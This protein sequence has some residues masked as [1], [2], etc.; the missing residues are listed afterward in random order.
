MTSSI[1]DKIALFERVLA[2]VPE[3]RYAGDPIL[4]TPAKSV[5]L[6]EGLL[7]GKR[8]EEVLLRFRAITGVGRGLAAPQIGEGASV[9]ITY[10][11]DTVETF[12][13]P[14]IVSTS[15]TNNMYKE[16]CMS[17]GIL[18]AEVERAE[19]IQMEWTDA[20]GNSRSGTFSGFLARLYQHE[21][22]H[23]QG[24]LNIDEATP[25]GIEFATFDPLQ[26]KLRPVK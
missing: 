10:V 9:F 13:N 11:D 8:L 20:E 17:V 4:R 7:I 16:L 12:I 1:Q 2:E 24:R 22:A 15:D 21:E 14:R 25:G 3:L 26:E 19:E 18:A 5:A 23:L 6:E